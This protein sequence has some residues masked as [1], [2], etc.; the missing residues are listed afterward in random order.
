M[1]E[2]LPQRTKPPWLPPLRELVLDDPLWTYRAGP[3]KG[4]PEGL[5]R[6][7]VWQAGEAGHFAVVTESGA[8]LS[9]T[10]GA[11][12]IWRALAAQFGAP[13]GLAEWWPHEQSL[14]HGMHA[15]LVLPPKPGGEPRWVRLWPVHRYNPHAVLFSD[16]WAAYGL[17]IMAE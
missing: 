13:L 9:V 4:A 6:L 5:A 15:D 3:E 11:R 1:A 12:E 7:R 16:W 14:R 10:N 2:T 8:G 17:Q